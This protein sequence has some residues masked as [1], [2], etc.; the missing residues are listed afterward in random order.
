MKNYQNTGNLF[1]YFFK[2]LNKNRTLCKRFSLSQCHSVLFFT[3][4]QKTAPNIALK[5]RRRK[6][7]TIRRANSRRPTT[8]NRRNSTQDSCVAGHLSC[9][10]P[11]WRITYSVQNTARSCGVVS[12]S[13]KDAD[14]ADTAF[15][16]LN[17][18]NTMKRKTYCSHQD[19]ISFQDCGIV[20]KNLQHKLLR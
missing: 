10:A 19:C 11:R 20:K 5:R 6:R 15:L 7:N 3:T 4:L 9:G 12:W 1:T 17:K 8:S 13:L 18:V 14:M 16:Y 2:L